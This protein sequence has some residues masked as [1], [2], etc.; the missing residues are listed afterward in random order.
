M[1]VAVEEADVEQHVAKAVRE[2]AQEPPAQD[3]GLQP[4]WLDAARRHLLPQP[5]QRD[6]VDELHRKRAL[7]H[8]AGDAARHHQRRP[9]RHAPK[10]LRD[11]VHHRRLPHKVEL[12]LHLRL[13]FA[14]HHVVVHGELA[15]QPLGER[16]DV[17]DVAHH[18]ALHVGPLQLDRHLPPVP[19]RGAV[20]LCHRCAAQRLAV[21]RGEAA[22]QRRAAQQLLLHDRAHQRAWHGRDGVVQDGE[23]LGVG[24]R[25]EVRPGADEL[26][27]LGVKAL[28][29]ADGAGELGGPALMQ[30]LPHPVPLVL[31]QLAVPG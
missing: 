9:A 1:R 30:R 6:A 20:H 13:H 2:A 11:A 17:A 16:L 26:P 5:R 29:V 27:A 25:E 21:E 19:Q 4:P 3:L 23:L 24:A 31:L 12:K 22:L 28:Q 18:Q 8:Q 14:E 7:L 15:A 10:L